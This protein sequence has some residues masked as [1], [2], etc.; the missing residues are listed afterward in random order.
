MGRLIRVLAPIGIAAAGIAL[1]LSVPTPAAGH[2]ERQ[3][4]GVTG[5]GSVPGYRATGAALLVCGTDLADFSNRVAAFPADL[6]TADTALW[7]QCQKSG[8]RTI[9]AAVAAAGQP[10]MIIKILP[11]LY[12]EPPSVTPPTDACAHLPAPVSPLGYQVLTW[13]Q[14]QACPNLQNLIAIQN[15]KN[16]QIEGVGAK[17]AD[18]VIDARYQKLMVVRADRSPG[19]Y[20]RNFTTQHATSTGVYAMETDGFAADRVLSRNNGEDGINVYADDHALMTDC[21]AYGNSHAGLAAEATP[22]TSSVA[23]PNRFAAEIR[24]CSSHDNL[25]GYAGIG[26]DS[27]HLHDN[28]FT[29]NTTG[30]ATDSASQFV[31]PGLPQNHATVEH[32]VIAQNNADFY[33][34]VR[35]GTCAKPPAER[36]DVVCPTTGVPVG[37]GVVNAGG[38]DDVWTGNWVYGNSYAGFVSWWVPGYWRGNNLVGAQFDT[39]H[40]NVYVD[41]T[42][43]RTRDGASAPNGMDF[44]WDGQGVGS[45]WQGTAGVSATPR[46]APHCDADNEPSGPGVHRYVADP[47]AA[48]K[49]YLCNRYDL[50][51]ATIP[52]D[53]DWYGAT[54]VHRI[55]VQWAIAEAALLGLLALLVWVRLLRG[56]GSGL[57]LLGLLLTLAGLA[58]GVYGAWRETTLFTP[59]GLATA[60]LGWF[61]LGVPMHRRG[62][63]GLAWLT[64]AIG[65]FAIV[66]AVDLGLVM[67]PYIPV[68]PSLVRLLL[69]LV[70]VPWAIFVAIRGR[71]LA[72]TGRDGDP[73]A[74]SDP[75]ERFTESLRW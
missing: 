71:V 45:C 19:L 41:N 39:S 20:L 52:T 66:G 34:N 23:D 59:I 63:P 42:M 55:E 50:T 49:L 58:L 13:D 7:N 38:N 53:C 40:H 44:W 25:L 37:A 27:V 75:L 5:T 62:R 3:P 21:E 17:P 54:G 32:N 11:G 64:F 74:G 6:K 68:P 8:Y 61:C 18:V 56:R 10:N 15:K 24:S 30:M 70:W 33:G 57:A 14:Q 46:T 73:A 26:G 47:T 51:T 1:A 65:F 72:G 48:V 9:Q 22:N 31:H 28:T 4:T 2:D 12:L 16:L 67:I 69:E 43:G 60:G 36:G 35:D 29:A